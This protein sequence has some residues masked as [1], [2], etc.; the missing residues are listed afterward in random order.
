MKPHS[1]QFRNMGFK[2]V[3][4]ELLFHTQD[5]RKATPDM[6][7]Q[8]VK[9]REVILMEWTQNEM[10]SE[11]K[12]DQL[13]RYIN[14]DEESLRAYV[15]ESAVENRDV[16]LII[17]P[18]GESSFRKFIGDKN[19]PVVLMVYGYDEAR[20]MYVLIK[21]MNGFSVRETEN[22]FSQRLEFRR[23]HYAFPDISL[24]DLSESL[25]VDNVIS[26]LLE[27]IV[28]EG[29]GFEFNLE[30]FTR[31]MLTPSFYNL[32]S[33]K[34]RT[35]ISRVVKGIL[36]YLIKKGYGRDVLE[37]VREK[38]VPTWRIILPEVGKSRK[39]YAIRRKFEKFASEISGRPYQPSLFDWK[40]DEE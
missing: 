18:A 31:K 29:E 11:R 34:K 21:K 5:N 8:S 16:V 33:Q 1:L 15:S 4:L 40:D 30:Y 10:P 9:L 20:Q 14:I 25:L 38:K 23:L 22:F 12:L 37:R 24:S 19:I 3:G 26:T 36:G 39:L 13:K 6:V 7:M 32:L 35:A 2:I 17:T 27:I 28:R